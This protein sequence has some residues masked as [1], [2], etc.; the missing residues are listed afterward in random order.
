MYLYKYFASNKTDKNYIFG[1]QE[2]QTVVGVSGMMTV[3]LETA[4]VV[5]VTRKAR[6]CLVQPIT[7]FLTIV[8]AMRILTVNLNGVM[9]EINCHVVEAANLK[10]PMDHPVAVCIHFYYLY[11]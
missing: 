10:F 5:V 6:V 2:N 3:T 9:V 4:T 7:R 8:A 1:C 11:I